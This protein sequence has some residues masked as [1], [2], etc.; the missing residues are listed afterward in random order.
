M[1]VNWIGI[2]ILLLLV[3]FAL[4]QRW[5]VEEKKKK[6]KRRRKEEEEQ[7]KK[8]SVHKTREKGIRIR[9]PSPLP[10]RPRPSLTAASDKTIPCPF[11]YWYLTT[12]AQ[13][14]HDKWLVWKDTPGMHPLRFDEVNTNTSGNPP[15]PSA[16]AKWLFRW[17]AGFECRE[18]DDIY[19]YFFISNMASHKT[20]T[21][22]SP[23]A[24]PLSAS[25]YAGANEAIRRQ[26]VTHPVEGGNY[27]K[28]S[29][30]NIPMHIF[31]QGF[32][33]GQAGVVAVRAPDD[34]RQYWVIKR[35]A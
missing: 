13:Y 14:K 34:D 11:A 31:S 6:K 32:D 20:L 30:S 19:Q 28:L 16:H 1:S 18:N 8:R 24:H 21:M 10:C 17:P 12:L 25:D 35:A 9:T 5:N 29:F 26:V 33:G 15:D 4:S 27:W 7:N 23:V 22:G 3:L 2:G